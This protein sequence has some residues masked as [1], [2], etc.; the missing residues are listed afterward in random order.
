MI[1]FHIFQGNYNTKNE[2]IIISMK[3]RSVTTFNNQKYSGI[4]S[5]VSIAKHNQSNTDDPTVEFK[6]LLIAGFCRIHSSKDVAAVI[7]TMIFEYF[8]VME[9]CKYGGWHIRGDRNDEDTHFA[10]RSYFIGVLPRNNPAEPIEWT[11][12]SG[13][14][15]VPDIADFNVELNNNGEQND[16]VSVVD[17]YMNSAVGFELEQFGI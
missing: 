3:D 5:W 9:F 12:S 7:T 15:Y 14:R 17:K 13:C 2:Y 11:R 16:L 6:L 8:N 1:T 4:M 10:S